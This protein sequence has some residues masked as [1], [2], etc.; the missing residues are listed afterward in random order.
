MPTEKYDSAINDGDAHRE[1]L[2]LDD[3][4]TAIR[5][6]ILNLSAEDMTQTCI[7]RALN[8]GI[9]HPTNRDVA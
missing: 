7:K 4:I 9:N 6:P 8:L 2:F 3:L 1:Q 5:F